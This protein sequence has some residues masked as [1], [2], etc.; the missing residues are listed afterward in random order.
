MISYQPL[1]AMIGLPL[2]GVP[3][4]LVPC[5]RLPKSTPFGCAIVSV[6][7]S[8]A[9]GKFFRVSLQNA[10]GFAAPIGPVMHRQTRCC[11]LPVGATF[12]SC[13]KGSAYH[14]AWP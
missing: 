8:P 12:A 2:I 5:P 13:E 14:R 10:D 9:R 1:P 4:F 7:N 11:L 6:A 3:L